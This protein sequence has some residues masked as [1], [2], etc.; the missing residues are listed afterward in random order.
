[1]DVSSGPDVITTGRLLNYILKLLMTCERVLPILGED[2][3]QNGFVEF[4]AWIVYPI[5]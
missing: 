3:P 5:L 2:G 4:A 1:M